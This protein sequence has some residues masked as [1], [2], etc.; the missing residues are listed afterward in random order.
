MDKIIARYTFAR[1]PIESALEIEVG[2]QEP[3]EGVRRGA[4]DRPTSN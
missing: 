1:D 3:D 4:G 2:E